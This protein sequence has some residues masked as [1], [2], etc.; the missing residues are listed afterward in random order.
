MII[1]VQ[2]LTRWGPYK[3]KK[4]LTLTLAPKGKLKWGKVDN[5][6]NLMK[7]LPEPVN[8]PV[9]SILIHLSCLK[10]V[11]YFFLEIS[12]GTKIRFLLFSGKIMRK[13]NLQR[14]DL[15]FPF[16]G[17]KVEIKVEGEKKILTSHLYISVNKIGWQERKEKGPGQIFLPHFSDKK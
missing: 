2:H 16:I 3:V 11:I 13:K 4:P 14:K 15:D 8:D 17:E 5:R 6:N 12:V 10:W 9:T 7:T 1:Q